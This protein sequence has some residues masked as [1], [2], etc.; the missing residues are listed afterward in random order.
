MASA[1]G[2]FINYM[3]AVIVE[4]S[5]TTSHLRKGGKIGYV[6]DKYREE[7]SRGV[8]GRVS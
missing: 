2:L 8:R 1:V 6:G 4:R 5:H 7:F 3:L